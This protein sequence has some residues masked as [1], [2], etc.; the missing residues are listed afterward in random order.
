MTSTL[1]NEAERRLVTDSIRH[2]LLVVAPEWARPEQYGRP[3]GLRDLNEKLDALIAIARRTRADRVEP[4][5]AEILDDVCARCAHQRQS[6]YCPLRHAGECVLYACA[7]PI[8]WAIGGALRRLGD[9]DYLAVH[10]EAHDP[11]GCW[12]PRRTPNPSNRRYTMTTR[13]IDRDEWP[14]FF[15]S[16]S[17]HYRGRAVSLELFSPAIGAQTMARRQPLVGITAQARAGVDDEIEIMLGDAPDAQ[18]THV[19][20][21]PTHVR[22]KQPDNGEDSCLQIQSESGPEVLIDLHVAEAHEV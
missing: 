3:G 7:G 9:H 12:R 13:E 5:L 17:R 1:L 11:L 15:D 19:I 6:A 10:G 20:R 21:A 22:V 8:M 4:Y 18:L 16:F 14:M 2:A